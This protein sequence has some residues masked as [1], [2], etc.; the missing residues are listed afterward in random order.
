MKLRLQRFLPS[1]LRDVLDRIDSKQRI[2]PREIILN[3]FSALDSVTWSAISAI[4]TV[5][6]AVATFLAVIVALWQSSRSTTP[7]LRFDLQYKLDETSLR[8][9]LFSSTLASA[10]ISNIGLVDVAIVR[11]EIRDNYTWTRRGIHPDWVYK[12]LAEQGDRLSRLL[13]VGDY[14]YCDHFPLAFCAERRL[15]FSSGPLTWVIG[16]IRRLLL[17]PL[18]IRVVISN[19]KS[20][21]ARISRASRKSIERA[22]VVSSEMGD[23]GK[24]TV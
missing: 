8:S 5:A 3:P 10:A 18:S 14:L 12:S 16:S 6:G 20:F 21:R 19:G 9:G 22:I 24:M 7:R 23:L 1:G 13:R 2:S 11:I 15:G 17:G 4:G